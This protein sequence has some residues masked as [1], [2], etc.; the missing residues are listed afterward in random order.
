MLTLSLGVGTIIPTHKDTAMAFI[1]EVD[2]RLYQAKQKG[3]N[4]IV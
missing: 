2:R 1:D 3:R 4:C